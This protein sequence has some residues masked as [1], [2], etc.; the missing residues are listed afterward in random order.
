VGRTQEVGGSSPLAP[1]SAA[2]QGV[3]LF[4]EIQANV[5]DDLAR[6]SEVADLQGCCVRRD[7]LCGFQAVAEPNGPEISL[8]MATFCLASDQRGLQLDAR[9]FTHLSA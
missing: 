7:R 6:K 2:L 9:R 1:F 3:C 5:A 8:Q 4:A